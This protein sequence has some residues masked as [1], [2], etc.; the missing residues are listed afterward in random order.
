MNEKF[1]VAV[2]RYLPIVRDRK[3]ACGIAWYHDADSQELMSNFNIEAAAMG[4]FYAELAN[5]LGEK[6]EKFG[7]R[8]HELAFLLPLLRIS[9]GELTEDVRRQFTEKFPSVSLRGP[10]VQAA[11]VRLGLAEWGRK[12]KS[13]DS[14]EIPLD[15]AG[16]DNGLLQKAARIRH[17]YERLDREQIQ[18]EEKLEEVK[19][20]K[21]K[22]NKMMAKMNELKSALREIED[23]E[24]T[25]MQ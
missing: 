4:R 25:L 13:K 15:I 3:E 12:S 21:S 7:T 16:L 5:Q 22:Y 17:E 19:Q 24:R 8:A 6:L 11:R 14:V 1:Q 10:L 20:E 2:E 18:L 9:N 23:N